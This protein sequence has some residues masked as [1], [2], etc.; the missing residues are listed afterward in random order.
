MAKSVLRGDLSVVHRHA[1]LDGFARDER[2]QAATEYVL[3]IGLIGLVIALTFNKIQESLKA[4]LTRI[5]SL[6]NGPGI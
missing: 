4:L 2:G 3:I 6:M 5:V 1:T